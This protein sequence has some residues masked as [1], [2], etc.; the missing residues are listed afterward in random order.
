MFEIYPV[1]RPYPGLRPFEAW[2]SSIF[3]GREAHTD[4]LLEILDKE[5]LL[6]VTGPS[7]SGKSSLVRA[8]LIPQLPLGAIGRGVGWRV[9]VMRPGERAL[10]RLA[11]ALLGHEA[12]GAE[13]NLPKG[14]AD[15]TAQARLLA[16]LTR[17][18]RGLVDVISNLR[19][20]NSGMDFDFFLLVDQFE[21]IFTYANAGINAVNEADEFINLLLAASNTPQA[22]IYIALTMRTDFFGHCTRFLDLPDAINRTGYLVPRLSRAE[23]E[24]AVAAPA[25]VFGGKLDEVL[26]SELVNSCQN[27]PD[28]L[29]VLQHALARMW[30]SRQADGIAHPELT[31]DDLRRVGGVEQALAKHADEILQTLLAKQDSPQAANSTFLATQWLFRCISDQRSAEMGGQ[32]VRRPQALGKIAAASGLPWQAFVP[33]LQVFAQPTASF[34]NYAWQDDAPAQ[35]QETVVDISHEAL[36]RQWGALINWV[37]AET[38]AAQQYRQWQGRAAQDGRALLAGRDLESARLWLKEGLGLNDVAQPGKFGAPDGAWAERYV[39]VAGFEVVKQFFDESRDAERQQ[40]RKERRQTWAVRGSVGLLAMALVAV[41]LGGNYMFYQAGVAANAQALWHPLRFEANTGNLTSVNAHGLLNLARAN[42][43]PRSEAIYKALDNE[44]LLGEL[45]KSDAY[46]L[47]AALGLDIELRDIYIQKLFKN[48][49]ISNNKMQQARWR[50]ISSFELTDRMEFALPILKENERDF[51][52]S[53]LQIFKNISD[54]T[55]KLSPEQANQVA[56][57]L[58]AFIAIAKDYGLKNYL[59][60]LLGELLGETTNKLSPLHAKSLSERLFVAFTKNTGSTQRSLANALTKVAH[61][62][63]P[64]HKLELAKYLF[65]DVMMNNGRYHSFS[66]ESGALIRQLSADQAAALSQNLVDTMIATKKFG[67]APLLVYMAP[68]FSQKLAANL[69]QKLFRATMEEWEIN[70]SSAMLVGL[71]AVT[72]EFTAKQ[73]NDLTM[74]ISTEG[75]KMPKFFG[76]NLVAFTDSNQ[77]TRTTDGYN[78]IAN[79]FT[80]KQAAALIPYVMTKI[81]KDGIVNHEI[82]QP[83]FSRAMPAFSAQDTKQLVERLLADLAKKENSNRIGMYNAALSG[84]A[85]NLNPAQ[86]EIITADLVMALLESISKSDSLDIGLQFSTRSVR[87]SNHY[88]F[89][90]S[91]DAVSKNLTAIKTQQLATRLLDASKTKVSDNDFAII[92]KLLTSMADK[93]TSAQKDALISHLINFFEKDDNYVS[94]NYGPELFSELTPKL[95]NKEAAALVQR[96]FTEIDR[97]H[98]AYAV[99]GLTKQASLLSAYAIKSPQD[100]ATWVELCKSPFADRA[101][102]VAA[103]R[104]VDNTGPSIYESD[105]DYLA[106]AAKKY[107]VDVRAPLK[108]P[109]AKPKPWYERWM[110][111]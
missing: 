54:L 35:G 85:N 59:H 95:N 15:N 39:G 72:E 108:T 78:A 79:K 47:N 2:E 109:G 51:T 96:L 88:Q 82:V 57:Q 22:G 30:D 93:L 25:R 33:V 12:F 71:A 20:R 38:K 94:L 56:E 98:S 100:I 5:H 23:L 55:N 81:A 70:G 91:L 46:I 68:M 9:G 45:A 50:A 102:I 14:E 63:P 107:G 58:F 83:I 26:C 44:N 19:Q 80:A 66:K 52:I 3:F 36:L 69:S 49:K 6:V 29:P 28:Q 84:V 77:V 74:L 87:H 65:D 1:T 11:Q 67:A 24:Q 73:A 105:F 64:E 104:K 17:G 10:V 76:L 40:K 43:E 62:L 21:E 89:A 18:P 99:A 16:E 110:G 61:Q 48:N 103:I 31:L 92:L 37:K 8:G 60:E 13:L 101:A 75:K 111:A 27:D 90:Q 97:P 7:G 34:L 41:P 106:W 32:L 86:A 4:H 42:R 53:P